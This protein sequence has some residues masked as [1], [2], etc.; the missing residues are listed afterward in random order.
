M[1][2]LK[3]GC[4]NLNT[5]VLSDD[6]IDI[7]SISDDINFIF[8]KVDRNVKDPTNFHN[9]LLSF[10]RR[11]ASNYGFEGMSEYEI[12]DRDN[13]RKRRID[14]VWSFQDIPVLAIEIDSSFR[15]K[16]LSKLSNFDC[17]EKIWVY[18]GDPNHPGF[19]SDDL[20][21]DVIL[22]QNRRKNVY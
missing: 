6:D 21:L 12:S 8:S 11:L 2:Q 13:G 5:F 10:I 1:K 9:R 20:P 3:F 22:L 7:D 19:D 17:F 15:K 18:Y 16:S 4:S 14:V